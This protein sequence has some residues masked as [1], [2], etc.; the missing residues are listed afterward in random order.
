MNEILL[1]IEEILPILSEDLSKIE[2]ATEKEI[3]IDN[4]ASEMKNFVK[5][6][7]QIAGFL[8]DS[9]PLEYTRNG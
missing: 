8:M 9:Q 2:T 6:Q 3:P 1:K 7:I 4:I 5:A